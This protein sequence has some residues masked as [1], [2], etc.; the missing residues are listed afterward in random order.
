MP[1][2]VGPING[3]RLP[4]SPEWTLAFGGDYRFDLGDYALPG[5]DSR[6]TLAVYGETL[7]DL[8]DYTFGQ[9]A[10]PA[11]GMAYNCIGRPRAFGLT[12]VSPSDT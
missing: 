12:A 8:P 1:A 4:F 10:V 2:A 5:P 7:T 3:N 11:Q 9:H 6:F